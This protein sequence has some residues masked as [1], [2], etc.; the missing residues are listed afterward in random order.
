[1]LYSLESFSILEMTE[2]AAA[3]RQEGAAAASAEDAAQRMADYL[4]R[5]L[6]DRRSGRPQCA[7][8]RCFLTRPYR[9]LD[10]GAQE[11]VRDLLGGT[12]PSPDLL[13]LA[14]MGT[15]GARPEWNAREQSRHYRAIPL[16]GRGFVAQFPMFSQLLKQLGVGFTPDPP[17]SADILIEAPDSTFNVFYVPVAHG[18]PYV[19]VQDEFVMPYGVE[20]VLGFGAVLAPQEFFVVVLFTNVPIT[21]ETAELFRPLALSAKLAL[22]PFSR[23]EPSRTVI[24]VQHRPSPW[25]SKAETLEQLLLLHERTVAEHAERNRRA[26]DALRAKD[27]QYRLLVMQAND[28]LY[29]TDPIGRLTLVNPTAT[30]IT[31]YTEDELLGRRFTELIRPDRRDEAERFYGRQFVRKRR[32]TYHELPVVAKDGSEVWIGQ[33]V[34]LL[35]EGGQVVGFQAVARDITERKAAEERLRRSEQ[36][37]RERME[38]VRLLSGRLATVQEEERTRIAR[39]LHDEL[40]VRLS[41]MKIDLAS[42]LSSAQALAESAP[43]TQMTD[44]MRGMVVQVEETIAAVHRLVSELR[45]AILDDLGLVAAIDW[46]C[47]DFQNRTKIVCTFTAGSEEIALEPEQATALF[48]ICQEAL[49]NI[50][51]HARATAATVRLDR[52]DDGVRLEA[53]DNG[54]GIPEEK[55][56]ARQSLGLLGMRERLARFGGELSIQGTPGRGTVVVAT[57]PRLPPDPSEGSR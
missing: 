12:P 17:N 1:M 10:P 32:N 30:R 56:A 2:C 49:T 35:E 18:S 53:A 28:I 34:Q 31:Q 44:R 55:I 11:R 24:R 41:C 54:V 51:R 19:P 43:R 48:R 7:L 45:P 9:E 3:L 21:R 4:Y 46:Q 50:A 5:H 42:L 25:E 22:L 40:G 36:R 39:E 26:Q 20:S 37:L 8:V 23:P 29:R 52:T 47:Q 14:L 33:H 16:A 6:G 15:A 38:E 57:L 27:E 13:C